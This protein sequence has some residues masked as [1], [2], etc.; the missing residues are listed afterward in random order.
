[1]S[2]KYSCVLSAAVLFVPALAVA[3]TV[4]VI[5]MVPA[6]QSAET[7]QDSEPD[8]TVNPNNPSEVVASAF[9]PNPSGSTTSAPIYLSS[10]AG[11]TWALNNI[12][13]SGNG[14]TGDIT[15]ALSRSNVLYAGIL[16][17]GSSLQMRI[18]RSATYTAAGTMTG[19][20]TRSSIDQPYTRSTTALIGAPEDRL[21]VGNNDFGATPQSAS[22]EQSL[23]AA[24]APAPAGL[25]TVRLD[26]RVP[27]SNDGPPIRPAAHPDGTVYAVFNHWTTAWAG[28]GATS[29]VVVVRDDDFGQ[30]PSPFTNLVDSADS[31]AGQRVITGINIT[32]A[33]PGLGQERIGDK[34]AIA[35]DPRNSDTVYVVFYDSPATPSGSRL[36]VRRS[37]NRGQ[38]WSGDLL[39]ID[40]ATNPT[41]AVTMRGRVGFLYQQLAGSGATQTWATHL[42]TSIDSGASWDD[43][44]L[45]NAPA[46]TPVRTFFPYLGDYT[47][48][49]AVGKDL[50]GAFSASNAPSLTNFPS[51]VT[52]QRNANFT[53]N[54]LLNVAGTSAVN[55]SID[56]FFF[57]LEAIPDSADYYVRDWTDSASARDIGL[58]PSTDPVFYD[59]SDVWNRRSNAPGGFNASDQPQ[60]EDPQVSALG[61]NWGFARVHRK[62]TGSAQTVNLKFLKSEYGT[63]SNYVL[64][65]ATPTTTLAFGAADSVQTL[66]SGV[67]WTLNAT[68][69]IHTC[70]AVE[71]DTP[72]DVLA[73]PSLV[74]RAPGWP[75][76]DLMVLNETMSRSA[77]WACTRREPR[78]C[79]SRTTRSST[80]R[81]CIPAMSSC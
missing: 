50:Y 44:T 34:L 38:S 21:Y 59:T 39:S 22:L 17:G 42:R 9:T 45:A 80:I 57:E 2:T 81:R 12:V 33:S 16:H 30:G 13:P 3:Q 5:N 61:N 28:T 20:L 36:R 25:G 64:A 40:S 31:I 37:G 63:G 76:T 58:E 62:A 15:V 26:A 23:S 68:D 10:D 48:L 41:L 75:T 6:A 60:S 73:G 47:G 18:L 43:R 74:G 52:Y 49:A 29:S 51:G 27:P 11:N 1:M 53:T 78:A 19:L 67:E 66:T 8:I 65:S 54:T 77:T 70:I 4:R 56:P 69:S 14:M 55:V 24:A 7:S 35:V 46:A 71:I 79:R 72:T 32:W